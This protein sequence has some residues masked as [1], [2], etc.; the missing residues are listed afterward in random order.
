MKLIDLTW[1][2]YCIPFRAAFHTA[3]G[4]LSQRAGAIV[5]VIAGEGISGRGEIAPLPEHSGPDLDVVLSALTLLARDLRGR[6]LADILLMLRTWSEEDR[7][8]SSL[9]Y[10]LETALFD[11]LARAEEQSVAALL[12]REYPPGEGRQE[13]HLPRTC[14]PVNAVIGGTTIEQAVRQA[15]AALSA[16]FFCLKLKLT[17]AVQEMIERVKILRAVCGPG[18]SLRLDANESWSFEQAR[19]FLVQ[20]AVHGIQYIEQPLPAC[21]LDTLA[22]LRE[23]SP[24]PIAADEALTGLESVRHVLE[25]RAADVL[26][27]K[28]QRVGGLQICRQVVQEA[29]RRDI[30]CVLTCNLEAGIGVAAT[31]HLAAALPQLTLPCG[32]ATLGLLENSLLLKEL[33]IE[34]GYMAVPGGPGLGVELNRSALRS[35]TC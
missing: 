15:M 25:M 12:A 6:E 21:D 19:E 29:S 26:I 5:T 33:A 22:R 8:S 2:P 13:P 24:I 1:I 17:G 20:C 34:Q 14:V 30:A 4:S 27:L 32:L 9:V 3:H 7:L 28:P 18:V 11:A 23:F 16:G 31:L 10:G 35:Y